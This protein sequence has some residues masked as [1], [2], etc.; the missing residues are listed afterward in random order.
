MFSL[1]TL[2]SPSDTIEN[3]PALDLN[4]PSTAA[5]GVLDMRS[6]QRKGLRGGQQQRRRHWKEKMKTEGLQK[7]GNE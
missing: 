2:S 3:R 1:Q 6:P 7:R 5:L 4:G